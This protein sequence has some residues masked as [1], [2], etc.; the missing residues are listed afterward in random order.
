MNRSLYKNHAVLVSV[1]LSLTSLLSSAEEAKEISLLVFGNS[2]S[3][4]AEYLPHIAESKGDKI[5]V[6]CL[7]NSNYAHIALAAKERIEKGE[8]EK[9]SAE[10]AEKIQSIADMSAMG[11]SGYQCGGPK[12]GA[13]VNVCDLLE[14]KKWDYVSIQPHSSWANK[15]A[16][17][18]E[19][20]GRVYQYP[21][22]VG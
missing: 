6:V 8:I 22:S 16:K 4:F 7:R 13:R 9:I 10:D 20:V 11:F 1:F 15:K 12:K 21:E 14:S 17:T 2:Y 18:A 5:D 19:I 3:M